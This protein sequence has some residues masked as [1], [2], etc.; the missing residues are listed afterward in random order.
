MRGTLHAAFL[1]LAASLCVLAYLFPYFYLLGVWWRAV[2][3]TI[4]ILSLGALV[5]GEGT[6]AFFGV[7]MSLGELLRSVS[8]FIPGVLLFRFLVLPAIT[9]EALTVSLNDYPLGYV[10]QFFQVLNDE[11]VLRAA[12]LTLLL[13]IVPYPKTVAIATAVLFSVGHHLVYRMNGVSIDWPAMVSLF[14]FGA[15]ANL[16]F[17]RFGH[18]GYGVALHY[19]WNLYRFNSVYR[20][21]GFPLSEGMT[22]NYVEGNTWVVASS[23]VALVLTYL[24][25]AR[26]AGPQLARNGIALGDASQHQHARN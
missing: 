12:C 19:A 24:G 7:R 11:I 2:P 13:R 25:C 14:S 10:H 22:F 9:G 5:Y 8:L 18:I 20:L 17:V 6:L 15:I 3:S 26:R 23:T 1:G 4:V 16:L 21:D